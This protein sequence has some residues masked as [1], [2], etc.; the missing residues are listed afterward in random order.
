MVA[1]SDY[2]AATTTGYSDTDR[3]SL[4]IY[5]VLKSSILSKYAKVGHCLIKASHRLVI[6]LTQPLL[7]LWGRT[8]ASLS[9]LLP[10]NPLIRQDGG[11]V[12]EGSLSSSPHACGAWRPWCPC[13]RGCGAQRC[14]AT[15]CRSS[16]ISR[17]A[18]G[19]A[20]VRWVPAMFGIV[21]IFFWPQ[22][23]PKKYEYKN[24]ISCRVKLKS[25]VSFL[26]FVSACCGGQFF[27]ID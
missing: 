16:C 9:Y 24:I 26:G 4:T 8:Q 5:N 6:S 1:E 27:T 21:K 11:Y 22:N 13:T 18:P 12:G 19:L 14:S 2:L 7:H 20:P 17:G 3:K 10:Q 15:Q 25:Y 23:L